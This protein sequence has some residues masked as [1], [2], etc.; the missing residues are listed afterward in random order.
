MAEQRRTSRKPGR[1]AKGRTGPAGAVGSTGSAARRSAQRE[2]LAARA[3]ADAEQRKRTRL[4]SRAAVLVLVVA[5]LAVSYASSLRAYIQQR[6]HI[7]Q[8]QSQIAG[9]RAAIANLQRETERW[10]DPA[11]V[12][13]QARAR[14]GYVARGDT[15][16]VVVDGHGHPL[17]GTSRL[18]DPSTI[19]HPAAP[20]WYSTAWSSMKVA[21]NP[22]TRIPA[23]T[24]RTIT[25][26][27]G[28]SG[29]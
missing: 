3:K 25:A 27:K 24:S 21:G 17:D 2:K 10:K 20:T 14:F 18:S 4:T 19:Q 16:Y 15:P 23:P 13:Q 29:P 5:V 6:G 11:Y 22:P 12:Q 28:G 26:P 9:S 8:L 1:P 7:D